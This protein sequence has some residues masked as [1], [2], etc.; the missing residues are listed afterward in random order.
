[1][2]YLCSS[3]VFT[4]LMVYSG[5][6]AAQTQQAATV[7]SDQSDCVSAPGQL[8]AAGCRDSADAG[9]RTDGDLAAKPPSATAATGS[10]DI[11][12]TGSRLKSGFA[13]P[14]PVTVTTTSDLRAAAPASLTD[15]ITQ[16]P[17]FRNSSRASTAG[18]SGVRGNGASFLSL[19]GLEP[20]RTLTLLDGRRVVASSA[21]GSPDIN[22]F[23]QDLISRVEVVTG[24]ASAAYGSD[25]VAGVVNFILDKNFTGVRARV[26]AGISDEGDGG[27]RQAALSY[28]ASL[29]GDR[30]H[31][32][33][34]AEYRATD[35][36]PGAHSRPWADA[37]DE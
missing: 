36:I 37:A 10:D 21:A 27:S 18:P 1:M 13:S 4:I 33:A 17:Q 29:L 24:G 23:P 34:S 5:S 8:A 20:Q 12:V 3:S 15:A 35:E 14:T 19:R 32:I 16:L 9:Q 22:L 11:I 31:L 30:I 25:A 7:N 6:A 2:R 26:Q 28:G